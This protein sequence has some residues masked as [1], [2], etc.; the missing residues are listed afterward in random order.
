MASR[1][2][3]YTIISRFMSNSDNIFL[4]FRKKQPPLR[5]SGRSREGVP[6]QSSG[7]QA[8]LVA[9]PSGWAR[10]AGT[11]KRRP[12]YIEQVGHTTYTP[13]SWPRQLDDWSHAGPTHLAGPTSLA[14]PV[15]M[16]AALPVI[17][18]LPCMVTEEQCRCSTTLS[19]ADC[20]R[21]PHRPPQA[22]MPCLLLPTRRLRCPRVASHRQWRQIAPDTQHAGM[23]QGSDALHTYT[24]CHAGLLGPAS[25][26]KQRPSGCM[27]GSL[28]LLGPGGGA[29]HATP[30]CGA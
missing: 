29:A 10:P 15:S 25:C 7:T 27:S 19:C 3:A 12:R 14:G 11:Q 21:L 16:H 9:C 17:S 30:R 18:R 5:L 28:P 24:Y 1:M 22:H 4:Q 26:V 2:T 6:Q 13:L 20:S 8:A 23:Q